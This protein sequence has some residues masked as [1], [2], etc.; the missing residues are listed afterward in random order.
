M[1]E[2]MEFQVLDRLGME[3]VNGNDPYPASGFVDA[4]NVVNSVGTKGEVVAS[5]MILFRY[6]GFTK[7]TQYQIRVR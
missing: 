1:L 6:P 7:K 3:R 5:K 4:M 2:R